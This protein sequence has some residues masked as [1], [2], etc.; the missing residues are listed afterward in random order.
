MYLSAYF[1]SL[2]RGVGLNGNG[3]ELELQEKDGGLFVI[4]VWIFFK[5]V[6]LQQ[7]SIYLI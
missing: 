3:L 2:S 5:V 6:D 4:R 7:P 1:Y